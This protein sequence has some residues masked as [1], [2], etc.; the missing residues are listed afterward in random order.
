PTLAPKNSDSLYVLI[1]VPELSKFNDWS[2]KTIEEYR[3]LII[4]KLK[5]NSVFS[6]IDQHI[7]LKKEFTPLD[8]KEKFGAYNG[9]T[10]GLR[11]TLGQSNYYRPH[12]KFDYAEHLYFC[13]SSTHPGAGVPIVMQSAKLAVKELI[14]DDQNNQ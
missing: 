11:P 13:G 2:I 3:Q 12:N 7:V 8:F 4:N 1:P 6:D 10:F 14:K 5:K 9:A